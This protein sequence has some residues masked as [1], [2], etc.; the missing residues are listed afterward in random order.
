MP[1]Q[2]SIELGLCWNNPVIF[3]ARSYRQEKTCSIPN[4]S[5]IRCT[6]REQ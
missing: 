2:E 4:L 6:K 3:Y 5:D 1:L